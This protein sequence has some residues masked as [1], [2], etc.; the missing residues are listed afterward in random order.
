[1]RTYARYLGLDEESLVA[2]LPPS[3]QDTRRSLSLAILRVQPRMILS[4]PAAALVG[5]L[6]L[7]GAFTA[8]AWRQIEAD[9]R[10]TI[11]AAPADSPAATPLPSPSPSSHT[12]P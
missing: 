2:K 1:M 9:Q 4:G 11:M 7:A 3:L 5:L 6:L 12:S 10:P 8:Y